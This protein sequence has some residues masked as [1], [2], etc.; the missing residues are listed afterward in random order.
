[1]SNLKQNYKLLA[2]EEDEGDHPLGEN[3]DD[4]KSKSKDF[5]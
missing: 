4:D 5:K 1:V 2:K 3:F